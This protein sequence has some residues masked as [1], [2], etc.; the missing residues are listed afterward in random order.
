[1]KE[2]IISTHLRLQIKYFV[3]IKILEDVKLN[4]QSF[5][6]LSTKTGEDVTR[7]YA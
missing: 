3:R 7:E 4:P 5:H 1:M 6:F 2:G